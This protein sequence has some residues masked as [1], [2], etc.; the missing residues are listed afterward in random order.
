MANSSGGVYGRPR[1]P[2]D[3]ESGGKSEPGG[4]PERTPGRTSGRASVPGD[5]A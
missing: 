2:D 5:R 4:T 1:R 3:G